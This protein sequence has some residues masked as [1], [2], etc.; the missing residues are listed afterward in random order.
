MYNVA[1]LEKI[2]IDELRGVFLFIPKCIKQVQIKNGRC[3]DKEGNA[4]ELI[5][6]KNITSSKVKI[7]AGFPIS[8][9]DLLDVFENCSTVELCQSSYLAKL[10][11]YVHMGFLLPSLNKIG[12]ISKSISGM[13]DKTEN[14]NSDDLSESYVVYFDEELEE[15]LDNNINIEDLKLIENLLNDIVKLDDINKIKS[16]LNDTAGLLNYY[17]NGNV[18]ELFEENEEVLN[19]EFDEIEFVNKIEPFLEELNKLVGL[20]EIKNEIN[21]LIKYIIYREK[22]KD[23]LDFEELNLNMVF[24]G[25]PGTG[26]TTIAS[27]LARMLYSLGYLKSEK[28]AFVTAEKLIAGYVGHT[29]IKTRKLLDEYKGGVIVIDEAYVLA[30][31]ENKFAHE[32]IAEILKDMETNE[33]SI[34]FAG[35][36]KEMKDFLKMNSG[37]NSRIGI[38]YNFYNYKIEELN[39][40]L[41]NRIENMNKNSDKRLHLT[42]SAKLKVLELIERESKTKN[43]GNARY[44]N[45]LTDK[46]L[47][48]KADSVSYSTNIEE[49]LEVT[50]INIPNETIK[51][52][53]KVIGFN[54]KNKLDR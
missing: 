3:I 1:I 26:K 54:S 4:F 39:Q 18:V 48:N 37:L 46:I 15:S 16:D 11:K 14:V 12:V 31:P 50:D 51:E 17:I 22:T 24:T 29:A 5:S 36:E 19:E 41:I 23:Y 21:K 47:L 7:G 44:I 35:Y 45:N 8:D 30:S 49:L 40:M 42:N 9:R 53:V 38:N 33:T 34:I 13:Y 6:N 52:K 10:K 27:I 43:F 25:N 28:I 2:V 20:E 32:A